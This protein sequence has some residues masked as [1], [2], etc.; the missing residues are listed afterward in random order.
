MAYQICLTITSQQKEYMKQHKLSPSKEFQKMLNIMI[1]RGSE[2]YE[3]EIDQWK[4]EAD[5][6][7]SIA[8]QMQADLLLKE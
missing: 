2:E 3:S 1:M 5:K 6:W 7:H 8:L 4:A